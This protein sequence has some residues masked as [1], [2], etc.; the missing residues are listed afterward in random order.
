MNV[1]RSL[2]WGVAAR[3]TLWCCGV[4]HRIGKFAAACSKLIIIIIKSPRALRAAIDFL[5]RPPSAEETN[6]GA[7]G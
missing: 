1:L 2:G 3:S 5:S 7:L 6:Q 4:K